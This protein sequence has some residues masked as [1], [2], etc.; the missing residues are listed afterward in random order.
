MQLRRN[1]HTVLWSSCRHALDERV[2]LLLALLT[3]R[4]LAQPLIICCVTL[5]GH[6]AVRCVQRAL[7]HLIN[8]EAVTQEEVTLRIDGFG[9]AFPIPR[10]LVCT[11]AS[12]EVAIRL[13]AV[14]CIAL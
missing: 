4:V 6:R 14:K 10:C 12:F 3:L 13:I 2:Q 1:V 11:I 8:F 5:L 7:E 9:W